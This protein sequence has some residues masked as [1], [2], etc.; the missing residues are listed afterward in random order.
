MVKE[1]KSRP[2]YFIGGFCKPGVMQ[3]TRELT[4]LQAISVVGGV[5]PNADAEKGFLLRGDKRIPIDFN[6]LV[7]RGDLIRNPNLEPLDSIVFPLPLALSLTPE[8]TP[9]HAVTYP[10][11]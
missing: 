5:V 4:L 8:M 7:Q 2:V 1:I 3:L 11:L 10:R 9:P 6:L